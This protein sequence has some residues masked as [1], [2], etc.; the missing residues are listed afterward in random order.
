MVKNSMYLNSGE[1]S[2]YR[3]LPAGYRTSQIF[4]LVKAREYKQRFHRVAVGNSMQRN[5]PNNPTGTENDILNQMHFYQEVETLFQ[6]YT[7]DEKK[8]SKDLNFIFEVL[9]W[10]TYIT[11]NK[12]NSWEGFIQ[13][14]KENPYAGMRHIDALYQIA[15]LGFMQQYPIHSGAMFEMVY[16]NP[17]RKNFMGDDGKH[18]S[19]DYIT[20]DF[21]PKKKLE[22]KQYLNGSI[23]GMFIDVLKLDGGL[24]TLVHFL[25]RLGGRIGY[26]DYQSLF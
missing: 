6:I 22:F 24:R 12:L 2:K 7:Q 25:N 9:N 23:L 14:Q 10:L 1:D 3:L 26:E 19:F 17:T 16:F 20:K 11:K 13:I 5:N 15:Y 21:N 8:A 4:G 18:R